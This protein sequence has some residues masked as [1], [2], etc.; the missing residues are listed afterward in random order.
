MLLETAEERVSSTICVFSP[1]TVTFSVNTAS[2][3]SRKSTTGDW[4]IKKLNRA[5]L[6]LV[7]L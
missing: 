3:V 4:P 6:R 7:G 2:R 5:R 1:I